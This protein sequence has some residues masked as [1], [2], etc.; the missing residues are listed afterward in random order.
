MARR[1]RAT[2]VVRRLLPRSRSPVSS[3]GKRAKRLLSLGTVLTV[4]ALGWI[5]A[6]W[7]ASRFVETTCTI[8][9]TQAPG[10]CEA[11]HFTSDGRRHGSV[12][13]DCDVPK[14]WPV[15][16]VGG[17]SPNYGGYRWRSGYSEPRLTA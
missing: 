6:S 15:T 1:K 4:I 5:L 7:R 9:L 2:V 11:V 17:K 14:G 8:E 16:P 13:D 12:W 3:P 10:W